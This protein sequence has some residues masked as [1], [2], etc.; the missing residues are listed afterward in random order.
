MA[1]FYNDCRKKIEEINICLIN[2]NIN[3]YTIFIHAIKSALANIGANELSLSAKMLEDAGENGNINYIKKYNDDF[4]LKLEKI[5]NE[6]ENLIV[7]KNINLPKES[8]NRELLNLELLK[9]KEALISLNAGI[10]NKTID[11]LKKKTQTDNI[12]KSINEISDKILIGEYEEA[13][14]IVE[15]IYLENINVN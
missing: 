9:L 1:I 3:L 4:I 13:I 5:L 15:K 14:E 6:I 7:D 10:I 11:N 8:Y 12:G 2:N